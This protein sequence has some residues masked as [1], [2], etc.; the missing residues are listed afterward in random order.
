MKLTQQNKNLKLSFYANFTKV[1]VLFL[2]I[3]IISGKLIQLKCCGSLDKLSDQKKLRLAQQ[4]CCFIKKKNPNLKEEFQI[5]RW[6]Q[7]KIPGDQIFAHTIDLKY[8][9]YHSYIQ[10]FYGLPS[11]SLFPLDIQYDTASGLVIILALGNLSKKT[12]VSNYR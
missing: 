12:L 9:R 8:I 7:K 6:V 1:I 4:N 5:T 2:K 11:L 3:N 10:Q